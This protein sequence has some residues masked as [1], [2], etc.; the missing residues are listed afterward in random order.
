[1]NSQSR[2]EI[3]TVVLSIQCPMKWGFTL[4]LKLDEESDERKRKKAKQS[5]KSFKQTDCCCCQV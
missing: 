5:K 2:V 1:M 3:L 4:K